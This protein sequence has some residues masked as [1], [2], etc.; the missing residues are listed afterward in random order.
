MLITSVVKTVSNIRTLISSGLDT[1]VCCFLRVK[2]VC[3]SSLSST[4]DE[5]LLGAETGDVYSVDLHSFRLSDKVIC[6]DTVIQ[7]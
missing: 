3:A 6:Q 2:T 1:C 7:R 5:L 4:G